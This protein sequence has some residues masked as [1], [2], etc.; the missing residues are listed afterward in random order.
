MIERNTNGAFGEAIVLELVFEC[1]YHLT[2]IGIDANVMFMSVKSKKGLALIFECR[3]PVDDR[4]FCTW[5]GLFGKSANALKL[6]PFRGFNCC[7]IVVY[8]CHEM[9]MLTQTLFVKYVIA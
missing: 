8:Y 6:F 2:A 5:H 1:L 3:H 4:F 7:Q 9:I